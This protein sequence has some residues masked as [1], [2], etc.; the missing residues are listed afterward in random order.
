[1]YRTPTALLNDDFRQAI[2]EDIDF[3][4]ITHKSTLKK[5]RKL[6]DALTQLMINTC[7]KFQRHK[8]MP[9]WNAVRLSRAFQKDRFSRDFKPFQNVLEQNGCIIN[10]HYKP[11]TA[12]HSGTTKAVIIPHKKIKQAVDYLESINQEQVQLNSELLIDW[13]SPYYFNDC[14]VPSRIRINT[15]ALQEFSSSVKSTSGHLHQKWNLQLRLNTALDC[16]GWLD[17]EY[18]TSDFGRLVGTG[19]SSLQTMPKILLKEILAGC[20]EIDVNACSY[21]LLTISLK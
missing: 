21:S 4:Y 18:R 17:Q 6:T 11:P 12:N 1:M 14:P 7:D 8:E 5:Q 10:H 2:R 19:L 13:N 15:K 20:F 9:L 16:D 3:N